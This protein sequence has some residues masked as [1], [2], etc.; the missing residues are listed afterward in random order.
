M[1]LFGELVS[2]Q[3][4]IAPEHLEALL[5]LSQREASNAEVRDR[6]KADDDKFKA[7]SAGMGD[8]V[9]GS[10]NAYKRGPIGVMDLRGVLFPRAGVRDL[11]GFASTEGLASDF[12]MLEQDSEVTDIVVMVDSPGGAV[13]G[14]SDFAQMV[15]GSEKTTHAFVLGQM[16][17]AAY[18]A[19]SGAD[20]IVSADTG[21][22]GSIG[23]VATVSLKKD[24]GTETMEIVSSISPKKRT[25]GKEAVEELQGIVD[26]LGVLFVE[27][28]A[29]NRGTDVETVLKD[30][31]QG[32][33][34]TAGKALEVGMIDRISTFA[35]LI[36]GIE[37]RCKGDHKR[38]TVASGTKMEASMDIK[39]LKAEHNE[40][41][42]AAVQEGHAT[43]IAQERE[44]VQAHLLLGQASGD[45]ETAL[46]AVESGD[47][48]SLLTKAKYEAASMRKAQAAA[49]AADNQD[50]NVGDGS[51]GGDGA[52]GAA[53][54]KDL[55]DDIADLV[56]EG[57]SYYEGADGGEA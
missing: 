32:G 57:L 33:L 35:D 37:A 8:W 43:G 36:S 39:E 31:G 1:N 30:F 23:V 4:A 42:L 2:D 18:W 15:K 52:P 29:A 44:R 50:L 21:V 34:L 47:E 11:Y 3:W 19:L 45:M 49:M 55:G 6:F 14:V 13:P 12:R 22:T 20:E 9:Q 38:R 10:F 56:A 25:Q 7:L 27:T 54:G 28:A 51:S 17:S 40:L 53:S 48:M 41:Y 16:G 5:E 24:K 26:A 46:K